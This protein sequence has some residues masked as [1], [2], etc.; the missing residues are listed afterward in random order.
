VWAAAA[1]AGGE[2]YN[3]GGGAVVRNEAGLRVMPISQLNPYQNRWTILARVTSKSEVR[4][5]PRSH[6]GPS[7]RASPT[8]ARCEQP[9]APTLDHPGARHQQERGASSPSLP[10][11]TILARVT[12]KSEVRAAPRSHVPTSRSPAARALALI[13]PPPLPPNKEVERA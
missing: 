7:W 2:Q 9:L 10:R 1:A 11:W 3:A 5:A 8:R 6:A 4:A 13:S 12:S